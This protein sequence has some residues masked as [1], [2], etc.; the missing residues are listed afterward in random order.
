MNRKDR[1][2]Y[3]AREFDRT[4]ASYD[5]S[6]LFRSYQRRTQLLVISRIPVEKGHTVL[7]LGC[8]T[9]EGTIDIARKLEGT[10]RVIGMDLSEKMIEQAKR[11]LDSF[12]YDNV[13]FFVGSGASLD[14][15]GYF[16]FVFSTNAFHHFENKEEIFSRIW[17]SLRDD[18]MFIV[19]DICDDYFLMK[20]V[21]LAGK[22]G[23]R[24]HAGSTTSRALHS[25]F[26]SSGFTDI[27][28][29]KTKL[30]RFWGIMI[31]RGTRRANG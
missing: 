17:K 8:G 27:D 1:D 2:E 24:A 23:E 5:E 25:L 26:A 31:G 16:D 3:V 15:N 20:L 29:E 14:Y 6:R 9:G 13:D 12:P 21:D 19:Q 4:A 28:I 11:K 18:G 7:D 30:N 10:G 22:I